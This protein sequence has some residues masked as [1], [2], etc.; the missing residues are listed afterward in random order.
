MWIA[1]E[2]SRVLT[3]CRKVRHVVVVSEQYVSLV[4]VF[5]GATSMA[6]KEAMEWLRHYLVTNDSRGYVVYLT[7]CS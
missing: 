7:K 3:S 2:K 1:Q 5:F 6:T 4:V